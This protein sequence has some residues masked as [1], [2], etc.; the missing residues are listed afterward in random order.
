MTW[1]KR[2]K[3]CTDFYDKS[4]LLKLKFIQQI[5]HVRIDIK[6]TSYMC[7]RRRVIPVWNSSP[8]DVVN[9]DSANTS[10]FGKPSTNIT[11]ASYNLSGIK[12]QN[13]RLERGV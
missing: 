1:K 9:A 6:L 8:E 7:S 12:N 10:G 5:T 4:A 13:I 3:C 2:L 11:L